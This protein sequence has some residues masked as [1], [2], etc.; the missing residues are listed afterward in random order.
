ILGLLMIGGLL[1]FGSCGTH[2]IG[3]SSTSTA[4]APPTFASQ[5]G[6]LDLLVIAEATP[7]TL[8][9]FNPTAWVFEMC[10]TSVA[11]GNTCPAG[12]QTVAPYG[13]IR[14]QL[15]PGDHL[16]MKLV[17][18]LPPAPADSENA[19]SSN[20]MMDAMLAANPVN[21]HTHGLI[22]EPRKADA[23]DPTYGDYIYVLG[24]PAGKMPSMLD[25]DETATDQPIQYD[26]YIPPNHPSGLYWFHPHVH[27]LAVNQISEGLSGIITIG[28][29]SDYLS[30]PASSSI[31]ERYLILK[32]MQ[33]R[34]SGQ[35]LDQEAS[36]FCAP[37]DPSGAPPNG[38]CPG[39]DTQGSDDLRDGPR[40]EDEPA[41]DTDYT[42]GK[43][44]FTVTGHVYPQFPSPAGAGELW[45]ILNA[46]AS[47]TYDLDLRDDQTGNPIPF[48]IV[49]LDGS[50]LAP[51]PG[52]T[53][54]QVRAATA[55]AVD[56]I[57]CPGQGSGLISTYSS[58]PVCANHLV[59][60]P[61]ARAEIW[62]S[63]QSDAFTLR[64]DAFYTGP[65]G[66]QWPEAN[67]AHIAAAQA[68]AAIRPALLG[69]RPMA[70]NILSG[71][72]IL[73]APVEAAF[74]G[75]PGEISLARARSLATGKAVAGKTGVAAPAF[76]ASQ[77]GAIRSEL[78][79]L[80]QPVASLASPNCAALPAGHRR[81]I[82][83]GIPSSDPT[84]F[85]MGYEEVDANDNPVP[86]SFQD[87]AAFDPAKIS[88][89]L[90][91]GPG[92]TPVTEDWE[93][94]NV[95]GEAH[96]FHIHQTKFYVVSA[97]APPGDAGELMDNVALPVGGAAC[98]G[99]VATW[100]S[101]ACPVPIITVRIPFSQVG[102]FVYHCHI[103]EH[104]DGGMMAHIRVIAA[105]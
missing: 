85:G 102:D 12:S 6:V 14:L 51:P 99:T 3:G 23:S 1:L 68:T 10:Q 25:P 80:S 84:A 78:H 70:R 76:N 72:G 100:R 103:G 90:P 35:V 58:Q 37:H 101:G 47:R 66:D 96:N 29:V 40:A 33:V 30:P 93:L 91:L 82:F 74:A 16:R 105:P 53:P 19:H 65:V 32:D 63:P 31:P 2:V 7:V 20:A 18:R 62:V 81:R 79:A 52:S 60:F 98:D 59:M 46:G 54:E 104:Q 26:I 38:S 45:R 13:G 89:C 86:G 83:F 42:G 5:N 24:Y 56:A 95:A 50:A 67:L 61:S 27:G 94:V 55:N 57:P 41:T 22:V 21:I 9:P 88:V 17:N 34:S 73:G 92:N 75:I 36:D 77:T 4:G 39:Q 69:V 15:Y 48:Q 11:V 49:S 43:W 8:G 71:Q 28:S 44:F 64:T 87:I 97:N